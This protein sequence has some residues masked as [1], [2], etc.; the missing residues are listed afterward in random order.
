MLIEKKRSSSCLTSRFVY[1]DFVLFDPGCE[2]AGNFFYL[3]Y[4][5]FNKTSISFIKNKKKKKKSLSLSFLLYILQLNPTIN[6]LS[7]PTCQKISIL[8]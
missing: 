5:M 7:Q 4:F 1:V 2:F 6:H 8:L 3:F